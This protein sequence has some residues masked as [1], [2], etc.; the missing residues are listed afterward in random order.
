MI[1]LMNESIDVIM[2]GCTKGR[3]CIHPCVSNALVHEYADKLERI[4]DSE[5][6]TRPKAVHAH[7]SCVQHVKVQ[8]GKAK[9]SDNCSPSPVLLALVS[10]IM[11]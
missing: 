2:H 11:P 6:R 9:L 3:S 7:V 10:I 4:A 5:D 1:T 8:H